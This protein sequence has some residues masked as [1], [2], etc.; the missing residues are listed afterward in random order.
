MRTFNLER[1]IQT[2]IVMLLGVFVYVI[3]D[4][5]HQRLVEVGDSAPDFSLP[6]I[7]DK[8]YTLADFAETPILMVAFLSNHCPISHAA[9]MA[10]VTSARSPSP[11]PTNR[12]TVGLCPSSRAP[13]RRSS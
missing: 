11:V 4:S 1:A 7:D 6:G 5:F 10:T 2:L 13:T 3:F 12:G 9:E 8:T